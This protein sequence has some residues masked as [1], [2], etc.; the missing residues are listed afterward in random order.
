MRNASSPIRAD[1]ST[2]FI[3]HLEGAGLPVGFCQ[4]PT[5]AGWDSQPNL[6]G[7]QYHA[8]VVVWPLTASQSSG[9]LGDSGA[10]WQ[11]PYQ[12]ISYGIDP[13]QVENQSDLIRIRAAGLERDRIPTTNGDWFIQQVRATS[14]GAMARNDTYDPAEFS[15]IDVLTLWI[16][17][18]L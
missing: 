10:D 15:Q 8:Y 4:A 1:I 9:P 16:S 13:T 14:I 17:K 18:E 3:T 2:A 7:S 11:V 5:N 6:P 12:V